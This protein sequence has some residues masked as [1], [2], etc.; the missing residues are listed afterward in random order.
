MNYALNSYDNVFLIFGGYDKGADLDVLKGSLSK[1][2]KVYIVG[3]STQR[4]EKFLKI[5]DVKYEN[6]FNLDIAFSKSFIDAKNFN[7]N[8]PVVMLSPGCA[9]FDQWRNFEERGDYFC[10]LFNEIK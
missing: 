5:N 1:I 9:S 4:I 7:C 8:A 2:K 6:C 3:K 10:K